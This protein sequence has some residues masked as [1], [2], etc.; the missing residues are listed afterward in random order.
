MTALRSSRN[1]RAEVSESANQIDPISARGPGF[2]IPE[3][4]EFYQRYIR[5]FRNGVY[6]VARVEQGDRPEDW[7]T[8]VYFSGAIDLSKLVVSRTDAAERLDAWRVVK[9][10]VGA[11]LVGIQPE[12]SKYSARTSISTI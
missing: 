4:F 1:A 10:A 6:H 7:F 11:F 9:G 8:R 12:K 3:N 5:L 2:L